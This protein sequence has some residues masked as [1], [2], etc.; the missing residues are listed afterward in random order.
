MGTKYFHEK[1]SNPHWHYAYFL[2][3]RREVYDL[4]NNLVTDF[5]AKRNTAQN[6]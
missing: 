6:E 1:N 3:I 4:K 2:N 5:V